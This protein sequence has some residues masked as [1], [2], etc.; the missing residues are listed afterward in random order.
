MG[1][2]WKHARLAHLPPEIDRV[3]AEIL[4]GGVAGF[5]KGER[6]LIFSTP[7]LEELAGYAPGDPALDDPE[8]FYHSI[9]P[10]DLEGVGVECARQLAARG[11]S[12]LTYRLR[13]RDGSH[14]WVKQYAGMAD[15]PELGPYLLCLILDYTETSQAHLATAKAREEMDQLIA[16][17]P[18]GVARVALDEDLHVLLASDGFYRMTGYSREEFAETPYERRGKALLVPEDAAYVHQAVR[19]LLAGERELAVE[20]RLRRKD[21]SIVWNTAYLAQLNGLDGVPTVD[22]LLIDTTEIHQMERDRRLTAERCRIITEQCQDIVFDWDL[23]T[24][25]VVHS[26]LTAEKLGWRLPEQNIHALLNSEVLLKEDLPAIQSLIEKVRSGVPRV[27]AEYRLMR[28]D[29][30]P[31]WF[32]FRGAVIF[33][34]EGRPIRMVGVLNDIDAYKRKNE[35]LAQKAR[36]DLLTGL[37]NRVSM[38]EQVEEVLRRGSP[39]GCHA[40]CLIDLDGF[41]EINDSSGHAIGDEILATMGRRIRAQFREEDTVGRMGGDEFAVFLSELPTADVVRERAERLSRIFSS[42]FPTGMGARTVTGSIGISVC[43]EHGRT[44]EEL[45]RRADRA[46]YA[47]K[48][49][50]RNRWAVYDPVRQER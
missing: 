11:R 14:I 16:A 4:P 32:Y 29:G 12:E 47:A 30:T 34:E 37:L 26:A 36:T 50:G 23:E 9:L 41:K 48:R 21:G 33:D 40:F 2:K 28:L 35:E 17:V 13:R 39:T 22:T 1:D 46:L 27:E 7:G 38:E 25:Q 19:E 6:E 43:P 3:L 18:G 45:Y 15:S 10:E 42:G 20:Y 24:D 31:V 8:W 49:A 44:F 5:R